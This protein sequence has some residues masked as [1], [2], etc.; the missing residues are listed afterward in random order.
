MNIL[1]RFRARSERVP[2]AAPPVLRP[3]T[4]ENFLEDA[5]ENVKMARDLIA[6]AAALNT[7]AAEK[8]RAQGDTAT[9]TAMRFLSQAGERYALAVNADDANDDLPVF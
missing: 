9:N 3:E 5:R 7:A 1:S 8:A 6:E 4:P 2:V